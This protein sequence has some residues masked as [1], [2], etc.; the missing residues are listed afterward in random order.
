VELAV[1]DSWRPTPWL[2]AVG[3]IGAVASIAT[4]APYGTTVVGL[5]LSAATV[6]AGSFPLATGAVAWAACAF[7]L[8]TGMGIDLPAYL[9]VGVP[10]WAIARRSPTPLVVAAATALVLGGAL[11]AAYAAGGE[12]M[13]YVLAPFGWP[14]GWM[15]TPTT[16]PQVLALALAVWLVGVLFLVAGLLGRWQVANRAQVSAREAG[17]ERAAQLIAQNAVAAERTRISRELHDIIA[18]SLSVMIAQADGGRY[19]AAANPEAAIGALEAI[20]RTGRDAL[21]DMRGIVR[22]LREEPETATSELR[23]APHVRDLEALVGETRQ[24][25][26]DATLVRVGQPRYL[27]PGIGAALQRIAQEALTNVMKHAG[28][29]ARAVVT[30]RW[31]AD[32]IELTVD[33]DGRGAAAD[34]DGEGHGLLGM[35]ERAEMLGGALRAG[36]GPTG[37]FRVAATVPL[38]LVEQKGEPR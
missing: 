4:P 6:A 17:R 34:D 5:I 38:P 27:P 8:V 7:S 28:P 24:A 11:A 12:L 1:R 36:P 26:L 10:L 33:D 2:V 16:V 37:G 21:A 15:V 9:L 13:I 3:G 29:Q 31:L 22:V 32:R 23:P 20:A 25:G 18:H 19:A 14:Q 35:R 30:E